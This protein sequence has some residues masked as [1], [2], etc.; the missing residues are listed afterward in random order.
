MTLV[1]VKLSCVGCNMMLDVER[2]YESVMCQ[3]YNLNKLSVL[4]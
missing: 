2:E 3:R 4:D 1:K